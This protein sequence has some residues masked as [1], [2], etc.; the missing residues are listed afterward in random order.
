[1]KRY[2]T[3]RPLAVVVVALLSFVP[4][5]RAQDGPAPTPPAEK[6]TDKV[7]GRNADLKAAFA[8]VAKTTSQYVARVSA[9]GKALGFAA[10]LDGGWALTS[11]EVVAKVAVVQLE[12]SAGSF[13][14]TVHA[15]RSETG[16]ALLK[17]E[18][19]P[20]TPRG[21]PL[22]KTADL[23]IG[24]FVVVVSDAPTPIAVGVISAKE[25]AVEPSQNEKNILMGLFSDGNEG[26]PRALARVLQHDGPTEPDHFGA[27]VVDKDGKLVG[28]SVACPWRG[29]SHAVDVDAIVPLLAGLQGKPAEAAA[30]APS[31]TSQRPWL[32]VSCVD[33]TA[34]QRG[35]A[36]F[37]LVVRDATGPAAA[38]GVRQGD[39]IV[40]VDGAAISSMDAFATSIG[41]RKPGDA[42]AL[43]VLRDGKPQTVTVTLGAKP[44]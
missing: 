40:N 5:L 32:G 30:P 21:I 11:D 3:R 2:T 6:A 23:G 15:R 39:V 1:M 34:A 4:A 25:R 12:G 7:S 42:V 28:I 8:G 33:A 35:T 19:T 16:F 44:N 27:P 10:Y 38:G 9:N 41:K 43:G 17:V 29:S 26:H 14:A 22:G 31:T 13:R 36:T 20:G 37:G 18:G 24:R